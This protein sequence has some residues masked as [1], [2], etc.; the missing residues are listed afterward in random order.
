MPAAPIPPPSPTEVANAADYTGVFTSPDKKTLEFKADGKKLVLL[1]KQRQI[2]LERA[3]GDR[4][5]AN[6]PDFSTFLINFVRENNKVTEV[7]YGGDWYAGAS[8]NGPRTFESPKEW[9][10][11]VGHYYCD[12]PWYG[13]TRIVLRKGKLFSDG[14]QLLFVRSDGK[15]G[16]GD[17]EGPDWIAFESIVNGRAM[18]LNLSGVIF[19]RVFTP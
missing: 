14:V 3:G 13:D 17:P 9:E 5:L 2:V 4:F 11:Y 12:S 1:H 18:R 7:S 6:D 16:I 10:G 15:F 8:Y 19:R